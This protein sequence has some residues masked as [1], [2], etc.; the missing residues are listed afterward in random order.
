M[1]NKGLCIYHSH[2][3]ESTSRE[4]VYISK[5]GHS[6][7]KSRKLLLNTSKLR[8]SCCLLSTSKL[9][10]TSL[11]FPVLYS[12]CCYGLLLFDCSFD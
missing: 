2:V 8:F 3:I 11:F 7:S 4:T 12:Y 10:N 1:L 6:I 9:R 5:R